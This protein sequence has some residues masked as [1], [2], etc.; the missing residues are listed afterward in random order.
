MYAGDVFSA[1]TQVRVTADET[2]EV[3][4]Y[5]TKPRPAEPIEFAIPVEA[6][7]DG[8][9]TLRWHNTPGSGRFGKGVQVAEV[10]VV[11]TTR[12]PD[13]EPRLSALGASPRH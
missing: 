3:H 12:G 13:S 11:R 2:Y 8:S 9:L 1:T 7:R 6:T 4:P 5:I 10:W